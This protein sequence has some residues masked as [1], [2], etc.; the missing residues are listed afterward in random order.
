MPWSYVDLSLIH[1]TQQG[2]GRNLGV[3][4]YLLIIPEL[5]EVETG[6]YME[7]ADHPAYSGQ[8]QTS[9]RH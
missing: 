1:M 9:D 7:L 4:D 5:M 2:R 8:L 6:R 3:V